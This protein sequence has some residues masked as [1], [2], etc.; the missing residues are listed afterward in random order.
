MPW[1]AQSIAWLRVIAAT[2]PF[3]AVYTT[4]LGS[5]RSAAWDARFTI[6]PLPR[7]CM[8]RNAA[9]AQKRLPLTFTRQRRSR[10]ASV[11]SS[12]GTFSLMTAAQFTRPS[13][14]PSSATMRSNAA[15]TASR[16]PTSTPTASAR[17][18]SASTSATVSAA[19]ASS[20]STTATSAPTPAA[21]TAT[22]WP[23]PC[24][25]PV[26]TT[27]RPSRLNETLKSDIE[28]PCCLAAARVP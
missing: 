17:R 3:V 18:P 1:V 19:D 14:R 9:W 11:A 28:L 6:D 25:P 2:A 4:W 12:T 21:A 8:S 5:D 10:S 23:I 27:T 22:P 20:R 15:R 16:S 24:A 7:G 13:M 26:T